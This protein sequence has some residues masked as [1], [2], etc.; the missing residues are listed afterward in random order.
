MIIKLEKI[1]MNFTFPSKSKQ[2]MCKVKVRV[3][4][5]GNEV[6]KMRNPLSDG[7]ALQTD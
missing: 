6:E 2:L 3:L 5:L 7:E 4:A 1:D